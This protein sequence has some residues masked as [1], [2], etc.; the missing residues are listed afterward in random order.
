MVRDGVRGALY[1]RWNSKS[2]S[3]DKKMDES[4]TLHRWFQLKPMFKLYYNNMAKNRGE[5]GY[6]P[7]Y[8]YDFIYRTIVDNVIALTAK[9]ELDLTGDETSWAHQG[10]DG[11]G[12][13]LVTRIK[14]K[15]GI[16]KGGHT[17]IVLATN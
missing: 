15:P 5:D 16:T 12:T 17:V 14:N 11:E 7:A 10:Y 2:P 13:S 9:A 1:R 3:Y 8:K 6:D 4:L